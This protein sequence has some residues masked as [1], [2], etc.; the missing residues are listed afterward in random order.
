MILFKNKYRRWIKAV[1]MAVVCLFFINASSYG[2]APQ[3]AL[4]SPQ[5]LQEIRAALAKRIVRMAVSPEA[6]QRL[7]NNNAQCLLLSSGKYL[8]SQDTVANDLALLRAINHEDVEALMQIL[9]EQDRYTYSVI[10]RIALDYFPQEEG[11]E[12]SEDLYV[13]HTLASGFE[14]LLL[15]KEGVISNKDIPLEKKEFILRFERAVMANN[16]YFK[17]DISLWGRKVHFNIWSPESRA[18]MLRIARN[19]GM[20]FCQVASTSVHE[21]QTENEH[22][23]VLQ[24]LKP[25]DS[26]FDERYGKVRVLE[27]SP[28]EDTIKLEYVHLDD[29]WRKAEIIVPDVVKKGRR[30]Y[31]YG[32]EEAEDLIIETACR[33]YD[34]WAIAD[35]LCNRLKGRGYPDELKAAVL[36]GMLPRNTLIRTM[37][38]SHKDREKHLIYYDRG[39]PVNSKIQAEHLNLI[40]LYL[41]NRGDAFFQRYH[42]KDRIHDGSIISVGEYVPY[43]RQLTSG[44]DELSEDILVLKNDAGQASEIVEKWKDSLD[45]AIP[46]DSIDYIVP[47]PSESAIALAKAL[48]K[49]FGIPVKDILQFKQRGKNKKRKQTAIRTKMGRL[50]NIACTMKFRHG[51][52]GDPEIKGKRCLIV[53][54]VSTTGGTLHEAARVLGEIMPSEMLLFALGKTAATNMDPEVVALDL[55]GTLLSNNE[56][57]DE[58]MLSSLIR[59]LKIGK[60][61][62]ILTDELERKVEERLLEYIPKELLKD[63]TVFSDG[64][65]LGFRFTAE[66]KKEYLEE[67]NKSSYISLEKRK[68]ILSVLSEKFPGL[69]Q[70]DKR[71]QYTSPERRIDLCGKEIREYGADKLVRE[72]KDSVD[73]RVYRIGS[74]A[75]KIVLSGKEDALRYW[76][77]RENVP[78]KNI[79]IIA[80]AVDRNCSD[81][82]LFKEFS[83]SEHSKGVRRINVGPLVR[84][85]TKDD[86][87]QQFGRYGVH[88]TREVLEDLL[89]RGGRTRTQKMDK[90]LDELRAEE[91]EAWRKA[92]EERANR[93]RKPKSR[94]TSNKR[95]P[96]KLPT[97]DEIIRTSEIFGDEVARR[98]LKE[99]AEQEKAAQDLAE[100]SDTDSPSKNTQEETPDRSKKPK[101]IVDPKMPVKGP[102]TIKAEEIKSVYEEF[103]DK[104]DTESAA[105][106]YFDLLEAA[107]Q[108]DREY[109]IKYD[110]AR[111]SE[112][113][114]KTIETYVELLNKRS[115]NSKVRLNPFSSARGAQDTF[116]AVYCTGKDF[117]GEGHVE[118]NVP[119]GKPEEYL[120]RITGMV[121]IALASS[122][123]P[124][125]ATKEE[126]NTTYGPL[127]GF[128]KRQYHNILG[129]D[130]EIS[131]TPEEILDTI[132]YIILSIPKAHKVNSF[133]LREYYELARKALIAA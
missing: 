87:V 25:G 99:V 113:Q 18:E 72:I 8:V 116:I 82:G 124:D 46:A 112:E 27:V 7:E 76:L 131:G 32:S 47:V 94:F 80:N 77:E 65:T 129:S 1:S 44:G 45:A 26:A 62:V 50:K 85:F 6:V 55:D 3:L 123:I 111:L 75:I 40:L 42:A 35:R 61:F 39:A 9:A 48:G 64:G 14:W 52:G 90:V 73:G 93:P 58:K 91:E 121:N 81:R 106:L 127:L 15:L 98:R 109:V 41:W 132:R 63:I 57:I 71:A 31:K 70:V 119:E 115:P 5:A 78:E 19:E 68:E 89:A 21:E 86:T 105:V 12:L 4:K 2:L 92:M 43:R 53:D 128:I 11:S 107:L 120:L 36:N 74:S 24:K 66:G 30:I 16:H 34:I 37:L 96:V 79:V 101:F 84:A 130:I 51:A 118:V 54:D 117:K 114:A 126:L 33:S 83:G 103:E 102:A 49:Q 69:Y 110:Q 88:R 17:K 67:Y 29:F 60:K 97:A 108:D 133:I 22:P 104:Y 28:E 125:N 13:N 56:P 122:N 20:R 38:I 59:L 23:N 100:K 10:K 95:A